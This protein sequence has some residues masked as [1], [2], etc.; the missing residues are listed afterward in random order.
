MPHL[1]LKT[2][3]LAPNAENVGLSVIAKWKEFTSQVMSSVLGTYHVPAQADFVPG[4][5]MWSF[6]RRAEAR[7]VVGTPRQL[8]LTAEL[9]QRTRGCHVK[10]L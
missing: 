5:H 10:G 1:V 6:G 2:Q 8:E 3:H 4:R 7:G 9:A